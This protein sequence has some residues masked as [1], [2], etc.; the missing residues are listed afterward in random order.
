MGRKFV[1][2]LR[3]AV[4]ILKGLGVLRA[5]DKF[6]GHDSALAGR[7]ANHIADFHILRN[8]RGENVYDTLPDGIAT[9]Q[10]RMFADNASCDRL[11]RR[12]RDAARPDS[13]LQA[14]R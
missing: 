8:L 2:G 3:E 4:V 1:D 9:L 10:F 7:T 12:I 11:D 6:G 14:A 13:F 5:F